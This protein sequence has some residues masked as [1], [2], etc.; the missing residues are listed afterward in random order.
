MA[1]AARI[2]YLHLTPTRP[3]RPQPHRRPLIPTIA[4]LAAALVSYAVNAVLVRGLLVAT[5]M[6]LPNERSLHARPVPRAGGLGILVGS[7]VAL[8]VAAGARLALLL[9][10]ALAALSLLDAW[11]HL[12]AA[13]RLAGHLAAAA[14]FCATVADLGPVPL[15]MLVLAVS[16]MT[17]L[18]NFMDGSD[19]L[20]GGMAAIGFG[21]YA[22]AAGLAGDSALM[23]AAGCVAAA[24]MVF[25]RFNFHPARIFMGDVGSIPLGFLAAA[26]G[27]LGVQ[28]GVWPWW[29][30]PLV[31]APFVVDASV[32]LARR[33]V[34]GERVWE[35]HRS[36]YY[37]RAILLGCGHVR[38]AWAEYALMAVCGAVALL[39][40]ALPVG[41]R[42]AAVAMPLALIG[43][44]MLGVDAAWS[45]RSP[46]P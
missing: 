32:T 28:R 16:W 10:L 24:A 9:A 1:P 20:A 27:V 34:R 38:T 44:A 37:Q 18:Y 6:D 7:L 45:R 3:W 33:L 22:L 13:V 31:F 2:K 17:N 29:V 43:A 8:P 15:A 26:L 23:V 30:P 5:P 12:P 36:H 11:R 4:I 39:A 21:T 42:A 25:L 14:V 40:P 41:A 19:G 35:A 46:A